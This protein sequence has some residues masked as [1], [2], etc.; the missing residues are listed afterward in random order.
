MD[1]KI[2]AMREMM[3]M[4]EDAVLE[5]KNMM[6]SDRVWVVCYV[7]DATPFRVD[8]NGRVQLAGKQIWT[9]NMMTARSLARSLDAKVQESAELKG[10]Y[11]VCAMPSTAWSVKRVEA[12]QAMIDQWKKGALAQ[13]IDLNQV[14]GA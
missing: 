10:R 12:L 14:E 11:S 1:T 3:K 13:G 9:G 5:A 4:L 8:D 6:R 7:E 2:K